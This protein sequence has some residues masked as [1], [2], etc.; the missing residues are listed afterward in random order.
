[1][2]FL[3]LLA[4]I[5]AMGC[6]SQA[7]CLD[8]AI[9]WNWAVG[10]SPGGP[11]HHGTFTTAGSNMAPLAPGSY[12]ITDFSMTASPLMPIGGISGG[13]YMFGGELGTSGPYSIVW[14]G[15]ALS[16]FTSSGVAAPD[17]VEIKSGTEYQAK[18]SR[19]K[20]SFF[21]DREGKLE[22]RVTQEYF[23]LEATPILSFVPEPA[24]LGM[25]ALAVAALVRRVRK[26]C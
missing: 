7:T 19:I 9:T 23:D 22:N 24:S 17:T 26:R 25:M 5:V 20:I 8:A 15:M 6:F 1:M 13:T 10:H 12:V 11:E 21:W 3:N 16:D 18:Y 4:P 2:R 14:D